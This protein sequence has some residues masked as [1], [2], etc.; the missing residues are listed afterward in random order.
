MGYEG[1]RSGLSRRKNVVLDPRLIPSF[2][3]MKTCNSLNFVLLA[4]SRITLVLADVHPRASESPGGVVIVP[5][6][7]LSNQTGLMQIPG[8][9]RIRLQNP[10]LLLILDQIL[11]TLTKLPVQM[12]KEVLVVSFKCMLVLCIKSNA[13]IAAGLNTLANHGYLPRK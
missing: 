4:I 12:I 13:F 8:K 10:G 3:A 5:P 7:N 1:I 11:L 6:P 9:L 2:P